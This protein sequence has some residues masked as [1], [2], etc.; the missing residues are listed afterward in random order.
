MGLK[1]KLQRPV[2]L[3]PAAAELAAVGLVA[4]GLYEAWAPLGFIGGG[5]LGWLIVTGAGRK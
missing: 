4:F 5:V 2:A 1:A 3:A